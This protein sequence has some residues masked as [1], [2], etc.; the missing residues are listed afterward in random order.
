MFRENGF[1]MRK[2]VSN[3]SYFRETKNL[4]S[5]RNENAKSNEKITI[6]FQIKTVVFYNT[7]RNPS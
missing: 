7:L 4:A 3:A 6:S 1:S 2:T 5:K